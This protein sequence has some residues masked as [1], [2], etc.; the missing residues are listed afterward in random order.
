MVRHAN[1][2]EAGNNGTSRE[3]SPRSPGEPFVSESRRIPAEHAGSPRNRCAKYISVSRKLLLRSRGSRLATS[4][5]LLIH[6]VQAAYTFPRLFH[7]NQQDSAS[8]SGF[9]SRKVTTN[10]A[11]IGT[12]RSKV[13]NIPPWFRDTDFD[14][15]FPRVERN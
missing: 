15:L 1:T 8:L 7:P 3:N 14:F 10:I 6:F 2:D 12:S 13:Y 5:Y 11:F 4:Y 9:A